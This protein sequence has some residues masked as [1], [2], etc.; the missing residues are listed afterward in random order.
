MRLVSAACKRQAIKIRKQ[1]SNAS[2]TKF[3]E[4]IIHVGSSRSH[5][6]LIIVCTRICS[7]AGLA[8]FLSSSGVLG[9]DCSFGFGDLLIAASWA[10][11]KSVVSAVEDVD[12]DVGGVVSVA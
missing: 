6:V 10:E 1:R 11:A 9:C 12:A 3:R 2:V 4:N 5:T 8:H 7:R